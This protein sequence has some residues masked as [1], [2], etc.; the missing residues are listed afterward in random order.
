MKRF[1][2]ML[3]VVF[4][5]IFYS[6]AQDAFSLK[7]EHT[8]QSRDGDHEFLG[9]VNSKLI[10]RINEGVGYYD[11]T[12]NT[13]TKVYYRKSA[14]Y[15]SVKKDKNIENFLLE[16]FLIINN[17]TCIFYS[18]EMKF[19]RSERELYFSYLIYDPNSNNIVKPNENVLIKTDGRNPLRR[20]ENSDF[21]LHSNEEKTKLYIFQTLDRNSDDPYKFKCYEFD[22]DLKETKA[23]EN[24]MPVVGEKITFSDAM[25]SPEGEVYIWTEEIIKGGKIGNKGTSRTY[26]IYQLNANSTEAERVQIKKTDVNLYGIKLYKK[27][28]GS[29]SCLGYYQENGQKGIYRYDINTGKIE[30]S[31]LLGE[32]FK[33]WYSSE[34]TF[35]SNIQ[36]TFARHKIK[37]VTQTLNSDLIIFSEQIADYTKTKTKSDGTIVTS[38]VYDRDSVYIT[39]LNN[40]GVQEWT[41]II[42]KE[43]KSINDHG[44]FSSFAHF[45][46]DEYLY[47]LFND[48][49]YYYSENGDPIRKKRSEDSRIQINRTAPNYLI[50][51]KINLT[52]GDM[53][54]KA[55]FDNTIEYFAIIPKT[56]HKEK[57]S[58]V[59]YFSSS[60]K[61]SAI[62]S[63]VSRVAKIEL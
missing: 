37:K 14:V 21:E 25:I 62:S 43:Q 42:D 58:S 49:R 31:A 22:K 8:E 10:F 6:K 38:D 46:D 48:I 23:Y 26:H 45:F 54:Q 53:S 51:V 11:L 34:E 4:T 18:Y 39:K 56:L 3:L 12:N 20:W 5:F 63:P 44:K 41:C 52:T 1:F 19:G 7:I 30:K 55:V 61:K 40:E 32:K 29:I 9:M 50:L 15:K 59:L 36:Y 2:L 57:G 13:C 27:N 17:I 28:D 35:D 60:Y 47:I 24:I 33:S 16:N